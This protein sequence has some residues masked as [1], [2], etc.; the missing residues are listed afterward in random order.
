MI[1]ANC[2]HPL[3]AIPILQNPE[4]LQHLKDKVTIEPNGVTLSKATGIPPHV[5]Q[6][7]LLT[8]LLGLCI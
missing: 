7:N 8:S 5:S 3:A 2:C 6:L 4:L 1:V